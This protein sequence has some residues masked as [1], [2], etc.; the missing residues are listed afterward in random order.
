M[1]I[2]KFGYSAEN[3]QKDNIDNIKKELEPQ[4]KLINLRFMDHFDI[5]KS[6]NNLQNVQEY[7]FNNGE[8]QTLVNAKLFSTKSKL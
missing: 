3:L 4:I 5:L 8:T 2:H 6:F 7:H 1:S